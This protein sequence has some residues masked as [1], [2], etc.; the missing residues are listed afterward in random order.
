LG[1]YWHKVCRLIMVMVA[2]FAESGEVNVLASGANWCWPAA[3]RE[4]FVPRGV[5]LLVAQDTN[6]FVNVLHQRR[7]QTT[8]VD[9]DAAAGGLATVRV[10]RLEYPQVPCILLATEAPDAVLAEALRLEVFSVIGK[11][12]DVGI[13]RE[14]LDRLFV[15]RYASDLFSI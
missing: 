2:A 13:L 9:M 5:N 8:I 14:Q 3:L 10:I 7:V 6:E 11:P 1:W 12:V 4:L 15:K